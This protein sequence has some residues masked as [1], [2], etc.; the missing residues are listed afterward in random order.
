M[1]GVLR[2]CADDELVLP[3]NFLYTAERFGLAREIDRWVIRHALTNPPT[4]P[5]WRL[6]MNLSGDSV[7]DPE[8]AQ[9]IEPEFS[10]AGRDPASI[11]F[12]VTETATIANV[13]RARAFITQISD[14]GC[15]LSLD[16]LGPVLAASST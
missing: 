14:L 12:E 1:R 13:D 6:A 3:G 11:V 5:G 16:D 2:L 8:I 9:F 4:D 10:A 15:K 7:T